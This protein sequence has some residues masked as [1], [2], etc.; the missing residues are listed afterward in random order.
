M[1]Y[2]LTTDQAQSKA[3]EFTKFFNNFLKENPRLE[4]NL[5]ELK[6]KVDTWLYQGAENR[7]INHIDWK[8]EHT[9]TKG[10]GNKKE[11]AVKFLQEK[12]Q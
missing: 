9:K 12:I 3:P 2:K 6:D 7:V 8:G 4:T 5:N 1:R 11:K 10:F